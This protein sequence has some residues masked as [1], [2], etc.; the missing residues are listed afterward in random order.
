MVFDLAGKSVFIAGHNGM[1]GGAVLR[2]LKRRGNVR[3]ITATRQQLDLRD[4]QAVGTFFADHRPDACVLAAAKVGGIAANSAD[5]VGF[6]YDNLRIQNAVI[7][8]ARATDTERLLFLGSSCIY[9]KLAKQPIRE[10]SLL[11]GPLEPTNDAYAIAKITGLKL[12]EFLNREEGRAYISAQPCNLYG[13]GDNYHPTGSHVIPGLIRRFHEAKMARESETVLWGS[14]T[15]L[16]EFLYV[17]DLAD[18]LVFL[19]ENYNEP[20]LI[21]VGSGEEVSI[22]DLAVLVTNVVGY[23]GKLS[24]DQN[25]PD[26]TP[27]KLMDSSKIHGLGWRPVIDLREGLTRAYTDFLS[28]TGARI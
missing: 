11:T 7:G 18:A 2:A 21:N 14:G 25:K 16:R 4:E 23:G 1:V 26:G 28:G 6:L 17:D 9:P 24:L 12:C 5:K 8:A 13:P 15:P 22:W 19:L 20:E 10:D 27:R 3:L